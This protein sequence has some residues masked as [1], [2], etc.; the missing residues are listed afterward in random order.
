MNNSLIL[1]KIIKLVGTDTKFLIYTD[2]NQ[3]FIFVVI[4]RIINIIIFIVFVI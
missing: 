3:M 2:N 4:I 1:F